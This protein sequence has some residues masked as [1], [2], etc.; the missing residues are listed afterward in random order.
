MTDRDFK[1]FET[2]M[3]DA[4]E[5]TRTAPL[6]QGG[7]IM[8]FRL[9]SDYSFEQVQAAVYAHF[10]SS[11]GKFF[12][13][14]SH[15]IQQIEGTQTER[16]E[17]AWRLFLKALEKYGYYD[18]VRF[19]EPAYHYAITLL[20][21][22]TKVSSDFNQLSDRE[23]SFRRAEFVQLFQRGE[24]V[25][26]FE[27]AQGKETVKPYLMGYFESD[28]RANGY[29]EAIPPVVE[30]ATGRRIRQSELCPLEA[31]VLSTLPGSNDSAVLVAGIA[32]LKRAAGV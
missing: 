20:G 1:A 15:I 31:R 12:P 32:S 19:P 29:L 6:G 9:L 30:I 3:R 11:E 10:S 25:A 13:T 24:R 17:Y 7:L 18:S 26:S 8:A 16:S 28:N 4:A 21:G 14:P 22:W 5:C 27:P 2:L 23:L